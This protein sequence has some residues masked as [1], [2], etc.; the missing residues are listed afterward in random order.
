MILHVFGNSLSGRRRQPRSRRNR[1][2]TRKQPPPQLTVKSNDSKGLNHKNFRLNSRCLKYIHYLCIAE[3][4]Y[5]L[6]LC[7]TDQHI[8][9]RT[10]SVIRFVRGGELPSPSGRHLLRIPVFRLRREAPPMRL[11]RDFALSYLLKT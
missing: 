9:F 6:R 5:C 10:A 3:Y 7:L 11:V 4:H 2:T 1:I 8:P